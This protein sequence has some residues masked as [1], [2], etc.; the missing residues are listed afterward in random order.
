MGEKN[1]AFCMVGHY[2]E[3]LHDSWVVLSRLG[4]VATMWVE[5]GDRVFN[6]VGHKAVVV[7]YHW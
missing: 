1:N 2:G 5:K 4:D 3:D 7:S 6:K